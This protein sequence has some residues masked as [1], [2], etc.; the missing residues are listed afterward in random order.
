MRYSDVATAHITLMIH[1]PQGGG[2]HRLSTITNNLIYSVH[3]ISSSVQACFTPVTESLSVSVLDCS[4]G[5]DM[6]VGRVPELKI[7]QELGVCSWQ[8][9]IKCLT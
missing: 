5:G 9:H 1:G 7:T 4:G 3:H 8:T 6:F 2:V